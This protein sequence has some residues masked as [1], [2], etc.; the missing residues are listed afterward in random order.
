M[1]DLSIKLNAFE[2]ALHI[3]SGKI[4][5]VQTFDMYW[6]FIKDKLYTFNGTFFSVK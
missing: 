6:R 1:C 3:Y 2:Y 5:H 4:Q